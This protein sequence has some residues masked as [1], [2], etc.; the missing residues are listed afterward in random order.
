M[1]S[2]KG[3][4]TANVTAGTNLSGPL[5]TIS[6]IRLSPG[7]IM[8][9]GNYGAG[10]GIK[11]CLVISALDKITGTHY[12]AKYTSKVL[13]PSGDSTSNANSGGSTPNATKLVTKIGKNYL[14]CHNGV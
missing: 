13:T 5:T 9:S 4:G 10:N 8:T 12:S 6:T 11:F 2:A 3:S 1:T 7:S 14:V